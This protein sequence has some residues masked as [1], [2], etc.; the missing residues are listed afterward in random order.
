MVVFLVCV[1]FR[2]MR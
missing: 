1:I 2:L